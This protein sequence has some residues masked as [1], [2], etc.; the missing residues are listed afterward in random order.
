LYFFKVTEQK[1]SIAALDGVRAIACFSVIFFHINLVTSDPHIHIWRPDMLG[2]IASAVAFAGGSGVTLFFV[3]SGFLLFMPYAR[4]LLFNKVWPDWRHY[5]IRRIFRIWPGYFVSL[6]VMLI[7]LRPDYFQSQHWLDLVLFLTFFMD[8]TVQTNRAINGPF[9]TLAVEWQ[10]YMLLPLLALAFSYLIRR[11][12]LHMRLWMLTF[13]IGGVALWG[14]LTRVWGQNWML[15]PHQPLLLLQVVQHIAFFLFYG[16]NGKFLEDFAVGMFI[17]VCYVLSQE[18]DCKSSLVVF[19]RRY[20]DWFWGIGILWLFFMGIWY[21]SPPVK[22]VLQPWIGEHMVFSD[23]GFALG[24]GC[25]IISVLFGPAYFRRLLEWRPLRWVG[26]LSYGL[27]MWHLP[28]LL[29]SIPAMTILA[30]HRPRIFA[31]GL[32]WACIICIVLPFC[33]FFYL[34]IER[35]WINIGAKLLKGRVRRREVAVPGTSVEKGPGAVSK[36]PITALRNSPK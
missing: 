9:W 26:Q 15:H 30:Q 19:L 22:T 13:C 5:C 31:Y 35:P 6:G 24:Y 36:P 34:L 3:L 10:F 23:F 1:S 33:Y 12:S 18:R 20:S 14:L 7:W 27:Y 32:Y 16:Q 11:G 2:P 25:C 28:L 29:W 4:A 21:T 8:S 17:S